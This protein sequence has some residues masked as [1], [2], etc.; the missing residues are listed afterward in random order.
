M[1]QL[2]LGLIEA[3]AWDLLLHPNRLHLS[4]SSHYRVL[5]DLLRRSIAVLGLSNGAPTTRLPATKQ[6]SANQALAI[7][8]TSISTVN[9]PTRGRGPSCILSSLW[10]LD[11][12]SLGLTL[13]SVLIRWV[14]DTYLTPRALLSGNFRA[15]NLALLNSRLIL[16]TW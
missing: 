4:R 11:N 12:F 16:D 10:E 9:F 15:S 6:H 8:Q 7:R 1:G 14:E 13:V 5:I 3:S 2:L